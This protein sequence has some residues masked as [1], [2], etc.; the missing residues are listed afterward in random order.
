MAN[1]QRVAKTGMQPSNPIFGDWT[2]KWKP[3]R[4]CNS[5]KRALLLVKKN[6]KGNLTNWKYA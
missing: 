5:G 6:F 1:T 3:N 2:L 4:I